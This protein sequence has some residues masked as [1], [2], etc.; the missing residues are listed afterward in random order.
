MGLWD[1]WAGKY[2]SRLKEASDLGQLLLIR[3][4]ASIKFKMMATQPTL[5]SANFQVPT[6]VEWSSCRPPSPYWQQMSDTQ[7]KVWGIG[8]ILIWTTLIIDGVITV[9][10]WVWLK[11]KP[12]WALEGKTAGFPFIF[13]YSK[14]VEP[15]RVQHLS[16]HPSVCPSQVCCLTPFL[17]AEA[18][19]D[20]YTPGT[21]RLCLLPPN[22][23]SP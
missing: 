13:S 16:S 5:T 6:T 23:C 4:R 12:W 9:L 2:F 22:P 10:L 18:W 20:F 15:Y 3:T 14:L 21:A 11:G 19:L 17:S 8:R 1:S 7:E